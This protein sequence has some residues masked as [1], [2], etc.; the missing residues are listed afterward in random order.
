MFTNIP[1][2]DLTIIIYVRKIT[3]TY[4]RVYGQVGYSE[5]NSDY[6][7]YL[8]AGDHTERLQWIHTIRSG[9]YRTHPPLHNIVIN[10][11]VGK[12]CNWQSVIV[13]FEALR[14]GIKSIICLYLIRIRIH[15]F[16]Y[17][18]YGKENWQKANR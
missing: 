7:L 10:C 15:K 17:R 8:V 9:T 3:K 16:P 14:I 11:D 2:T 4:I 13:N 12:P 18:P 6:T 5:Q 1:S